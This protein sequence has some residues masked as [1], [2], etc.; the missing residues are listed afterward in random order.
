MRKYY[1]PYF[2]PHQTGLIFRPD[3]PAH[4]SGFAIAVNGDKDPGKRHFLRVVAARLVF[5]H[6]DC[7]FKFEELFRFGVV[8]LR[9]V[10]FVLDLLGLCV[11]VLVERALFGRK[12]QV[13]V[14]AAVPVAFVPVK[15]RIDLNPCPAFGLD[16]LF[17]FPVSFRRGRS[18]DRHR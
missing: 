2:G 11:K 6:L 18:E 17:D 15:I 10:P 14:D 1:R 9:F 13:F 16:F 12:D 3:I 8:A 5:D 4:D 7:T